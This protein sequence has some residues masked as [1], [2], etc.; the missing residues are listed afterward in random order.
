MAKKQGVPIQLILEG[1][2]HGLIGISEVQAETLAERY[3]GFKS[4]TEVTLSRVEIELIEQLERNAV[5]TREASQSWETGHRVQRTARKQELRKIKRE[6]KVQD[7]P[8]L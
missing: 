3:K 5:S 4:G 1:V 7:T 8:N 2:R 6:E